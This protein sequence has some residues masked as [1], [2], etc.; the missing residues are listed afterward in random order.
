MLQTNGFARWSWRLALLVF[1]SQ[2][3]KHQPTSACLLQALEDVTQILW[4][5]FPPSLL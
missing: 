5:F 1:S 3:D 2:A 4:E